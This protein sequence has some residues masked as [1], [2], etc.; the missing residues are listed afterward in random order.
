MNNNEYIIQFS[1]YVYAEDK[2]VPF[3]ITY[4]DYTEYIKA[5][6]EFI[7]KGYKIT[8]WIIRGDDK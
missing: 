8:A 2:D 5:I 1:D 3:E 4:T 6:M 7:S